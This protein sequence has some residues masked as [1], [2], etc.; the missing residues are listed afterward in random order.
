MRLLIAATLAIATLALIACAQDGN[1]EDSLVQNGDAELRAKV[2]GENWVYRNFRVG[3]DAAV[4]AVMATLDM[5]AYFKLVPD[6][7]RNT[8]MTRFEGSVCF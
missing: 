7:V 8:M 3:V 5:E 6:V 2:I 4:E 1:S